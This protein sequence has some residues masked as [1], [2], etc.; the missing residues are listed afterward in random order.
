[1][2]IDH[3]DLQECYHQPAPPSLDGYCGAL[4]TGLG[5]GGGFLLPLLGVLVLEVLWTAVLLL[6]V[7]WTAVL[8][9]EV[10]LGAEDFRK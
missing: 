10:L 3:T 2:L 4:A 8:L 9:L 7:L 1:V 6:E 5:G